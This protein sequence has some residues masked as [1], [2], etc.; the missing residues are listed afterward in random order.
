MSTSVPISGFT[1]VR[2]AVKLDFPVL[3]SIRSILPV[4]EEMVVNVGKSDDD[5]LDL[6]RSLDD[7]RIRIVEAEWDWSDKILAL[8]RETRRAMAACRF[9]WG[10]YIQADEVLSEGGD[11]ILQQAVQEVH[12]D[13]SVEGLL[14]N[15]LHFYGDFS[16][17]ATNRRWY[18]REVR[19]MR[20]DPAFDVH[21]YLDAQ[22]FRVGPGNRRIRVRPTDA[23]IYHYGW[24]RPPAMI[25][26]KREFTRS[27]YPEKEQGERP[28]LPWIPLLRP[29]PGPHP[30]VA[31]AWVAERSPAPGELRVSEPRFDW[32]W[33][34]LYA[35]NV[36]KQ[37]TGMHPF[38]FRNYDVV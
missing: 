2:N 8:G 22:G 3:E 15:Y 9:P 14:V 27:L 12:P 25:Q 36:I 7:P 26:R 24:A 11:T 4:C 23:A 17:I 30:S 37:L 5:T 29:F 34:R 6:I 32:R 20:L 13:R 21:P 38:E 1:I 10:I 19:C 35:S 16:T 33:P 31:R 18:Q 28:L